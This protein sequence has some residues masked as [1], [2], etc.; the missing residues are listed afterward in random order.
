[1]N[2]SR[3]GAAF[4]M[5]TLARMV[6]Y[7][8]EPAPERNAPCHCGSGR[9]Y[10]KCCAEV[11]AR[12]ASTERKKASSIQHF[13]Y[14]EA[15]PEALKLKADVDRR[16]RGIREYLARDFGVQINI[17]PPVELGGKRV[18]A[19]GNRVFGDRPPNETFHEFILGLLGEAL[20]R[21][22]MAVQG[23][24]PTAD[25]HYLY[26]C[27][28]DY[29][30]WTQRVSHESDR[31]D[32][33]RWGA[34]ATGSV[35]YLMSLAWDVALLLQASGRPLPV[36]LLARLRDPV[37]YQGARYELAIAALFARIDCEIEFLDDE[38]LKDRKH[39]EF[40]A[41]HRP[42]GERYAVEAKS[43]HREGVINQPGEFDI[44]DP[45]RGDKRGVRNL[46]RKAMEKDAGG[47][48]F[49]IFVDI[50]APVEP[51][52][53]GIEPKWETEMKKMVGRMPAMT[54]E[55]EATF[56]AVYVTNFSP[57]YEGDAQPR[58]GEWLCV[59]PTDAKTPPSFRTFEE[60]NYALDR[61]E[62]VPDVGA[63]GK[64]R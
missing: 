41:T 6:T 33:G 45:L 5:P 30:A 44:E 39:G 14:D 34:T 3:A 61:L 21:D 57:H 29:G 25:R 54:G 51:V 38:K 31:D 11:D 52:V 27:I 16:Q 9:K 63:D 7:V 46:I 4:S 18:W 19:I 40:V 24:L 49:L 22:W 43:R 26:R 42:S 1:V 48:P 59:A 55:Q 56:E 2:P 47:D 15:P 60:L 35:Q 50:N 36:S 32:R 20:G 12:A 64:V 23:S 8:S 62:K 28:G 37:A 17:G 13:T 10:K 53:P 58:G